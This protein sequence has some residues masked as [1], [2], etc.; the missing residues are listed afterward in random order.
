[1]RTWFLRQF[2]YLLDERRRRSGDKPESLLARR[3]IDDWLATLGVNA[4]T[5][6]IVRV[7]LFRHASVLAR[8]EKT[9]IVVA[10]N[11]TVDRYMRVSRQPS[12]T[13][14]LLAIVEDRGLARRGDPLAERWTAM[15]SLLRALFVHVPDATLARSCAAVEWM[16]DAREAVEACAGGAIVAFDPEVLVLAFRFWQRFDYRE[17]DL[18]LCWETAAMLRRD[19]ISLR[20]ARE[21][22]D[23]YGPE[24]LMALH[25]LLG[26][27]GLD[28]DALNSLLLHSKE[29]ERAPSP[30]TRVTAMIETVQRWDEDERPAHGFVASART[31]VAKYALAEAGAN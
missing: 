18:S 21:F 26:G 29:F 10:A 17:I 1:M 3:L 30:E 25:R 20:L 4:R 19:R 11:A 24:S 15:T 8:E 23:L 13:F 6:R 5:A 22:L 2:L 27:K 9:S 7:R 12:E 28:Q 16:H 31:A 14:A